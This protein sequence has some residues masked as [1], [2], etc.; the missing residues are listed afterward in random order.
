[1][2]YSRSRSY[3]RKRRVSPS[4]SR[5]RSQKRDSYPRRSSSRRRY[6]ETRYRSTSRSR[7]RTRR[8][9]QGGKKVFLG[10]L[11]ATT[12]EFHIEETFSKVG[13]LVDIYLPRDRENRGNRGF[14]FVTFEDA[15]DAKD[16]C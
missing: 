3:S 15:Y 1:M 7:S 2:G 4:L 10:N 11:E 12:D 16:A 5:G 9:S 13:K 8:V 6:R 14:A